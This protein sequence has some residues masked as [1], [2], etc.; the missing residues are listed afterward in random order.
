MSFLAS[1]ILYTNPAQCSPL[2][3][4]EIAKFVTDDITIR[5]A[6]ITADFTTLLYNSNCRFQD[7]IDTYEFN[8]YVKGTKALFNPKKSHVDLIGDVV[9]TDGKISFKF[10]E[11]LAF[12]IPFNPKVKLTGRVELSRDDGGLIYYSREYWDQ[13]VLS[14][15]KTVSF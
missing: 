5:Q 10:K 8:Q 4:L 12:N 15:L 3:N 13:P 9:V 2:S 11:T 6:L 14:V 7:E 1:V